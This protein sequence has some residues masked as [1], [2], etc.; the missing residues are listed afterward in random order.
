MDVY[1]G[2]VYQELYNAGSLNNENNI[3]FA[4]ST[5]DVQIFKSSKVSMWPVYMLINELPL[6]QRKA[7][8]Y[9]SDIWISPKK[10]VMWS[11]LKPMYEELKVLENGCE[12]KD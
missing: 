11:F 4:M 1:D 10:P 5:D 2:H 7:R 9:F 6:S 8:E 3:S 12:F